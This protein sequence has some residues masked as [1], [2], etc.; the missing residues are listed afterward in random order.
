MMIVLLAVLAVAVSGDHHHAFSSQHVH[1]HDGHHEVTHPKYHFEY[2]IEDHHTKDHH[3]Q[4]EERD[5][6]VVKG[7]YEL[8]QPD[9]SIRHVHYHA[10][11]HSG[12]HADVKFSTHHE[13]HHHH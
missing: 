13:H 12:F 6:D 3:S 7:Y 2:K 9:G 10:D 1:K 11:K 4:H 5:G 8:K